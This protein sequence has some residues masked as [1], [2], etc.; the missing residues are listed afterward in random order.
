M[1]KFASKDARDG[2]YRRWLVLS[3][4]MVIVL[5][6]VACQPA[7]P[8]AGDQGPTDTGGAGTEAVDTGADE[9]A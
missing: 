7:G 3:L 8:S 6:L 5:L 4:L 9:E 1:I 2:H